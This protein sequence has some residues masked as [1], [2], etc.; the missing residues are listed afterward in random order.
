MNT[1]RRIRSAFL[2]ATALLLCLCS[3]QATHFRFGHLSWRRLG[4]GTAPGSHLVEISVTEAWRATFLGF[5][6]LS[7][8][9]GDGSGGFSTSAA[10][11][12]PILSDVAGEQY[13]V[14]TAKVVHQYSG[15]G[16]FL[17]SGSSCCRISSLVN[18]GDDD[19]RLDM[20]VDLRNGNLGSPVASIPIMLQLPRG[21]NTVPLAIGD[22]DLDPITCRLATASESQIGSLASAGGNTVSVTRG[23]ELVWNTS[24][25]TVGQKYAVQIIIEENH[26]GN[27]PTARN[28]LD[29]IIEIV[30]GT[31]NQPPTCT[32]TSGNQVIPSGSSFIANFTG[33]DPEGQP[34]TVSY[35]GLPGTAVVSPANGASGASPLASSI[36]WTPDVTDRGSA[37]SVTVVYT[38]AGRLQS[39]CTFS[40]SVPNNTAPTVDCPAAAALTSAGT[41]DVTFDLTDADGDG[42]SYSILV[43]G[44]P[45]AAGL[46]PA[47]SAPNAVTLTR[48]LGP[49]AG[50]SHVVEIQVT[51]GIFTDSCR[52]IVSVDQPP[53]VRASCGAIASGS[54]CTLSASD[55]SDPT[56]KIYV[57]DS[58]SA[59]V[60]GPFTHANQVVIRI[61]PSRTP[62]QRPG[63][64]TIKAQIS[65]KGSPL[66]FGIDSNG[67]AST[68]APF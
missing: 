6:E 43:D 1:L 13:R 55:D 2:V 63:T 37:H 59:F 58:A 5:G 66:L 53:S 46:V 57:K 30:G 26:P 54:I 68:P 38:D 67:N 15:N 28:A 25:T 65:L 51:D 21:P 7:Y 64:G 27:S 50:P 42:M 33:T 14:G 20:V 23:C 12:G 61:N 40:M 29:F 4:P 11:L 56:P 39:S 8:A 47:G 44:V 3:A 16:P 62:F 45:A 18:A 35:L 17:V 32:G 19:E 36:S 52:F 60:A 10:V 34:L 41:L 49:L 24:A 48:T 22:G 9:Y 31:I